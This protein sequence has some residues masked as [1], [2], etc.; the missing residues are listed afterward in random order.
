MFAKA[1]KKHSDPDRRIRYARDRKIVMKNV[2]AKADELT[3]LGFLVRRP[4]RGPWSESFA[5]HMGY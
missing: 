1:W 4:A 5:R 2:E 3:T